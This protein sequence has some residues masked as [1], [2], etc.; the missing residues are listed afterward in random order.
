[1]AHHK[2]AIK[3]IRQ[4]AKRRLINRYYSKTAF[5]ALK[6]FKDGKDKKK[7]QEQFPKIVSMVDKLVKRKIIHKN[8]AAHIKS[9]LNKY[10]TSL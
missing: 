2:S 7:A 10:V 1:M 8:K 3:R 4:S 6:K 5:N 9:K